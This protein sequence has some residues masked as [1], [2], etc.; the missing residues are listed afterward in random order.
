MSRYWNDEE[1]TKETI[2]SDN[3]C[4]SGDLAIIDESG[5]C[6]ITGRTKDMIIRGGE[7]IYPIEIEEFFIKHKSVQDIQIIGVDDAKMGQEVCAW[8]SLQEGEELTVDE[9]R[10]YATGQIAH[11]KIP[12]YVR[13]V[14]SYPSTVTGKIKKNVMRD[15]TNEMI[16][17]G[18]QEIQEMGFKKKEIN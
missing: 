11:Y 16:N 15:I 12:R 9:L 10:E 13:F 3:W 14:E 6:K 8:I 2:D 17:N 4:H 5:F 18:D 7:N 1:K